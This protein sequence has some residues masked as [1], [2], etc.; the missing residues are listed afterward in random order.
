L[1][2]ICTKSSCCMK[3]GSTTGTCMASEGALHRVLTSL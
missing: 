2:L 3:I 1:W